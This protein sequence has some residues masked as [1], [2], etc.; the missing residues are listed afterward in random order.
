V[1]CEY[2]RSLTSEVDPSAQEED[3]SE[4][5]ASSSKDADITARLSTEAVDPPHTVSTR[6]RFEGIVVQ[7]RNSGVRIVALRNG[8]FG[9]LWGD[10]Y[11]ATTSLE[12]SAIETVQLGARV[13]VE[14]I[15]IVGTCYTG[16]HS[17]TLQL[18]EVV[19]ANWE[20]TKQRYAIGQAIS[21]SIVWQGTGG[22]VVAL[23]DG[24]SGWLPDRGV[25]RSL[26]M[27]T[28]CEPLVTGQ[29]VDL[30]VTGYT[31]EYRRLLLKRKSNPDKPMS[32][33][34][35]STLFEIG[36][37]IEGVI[38]GRGTSGSVVWISDGLSGWL[39]DTELSWSRNDRTLSNS[40]VIG[41][42]VRLKYIGYDSKHHKFLLS[43]RQVQ[44]HPLDYA[45]ESVFLGN[46]YRGIVSNVLNYGVFVCLPVGFDGLI[47][48][49]H[50]PEG[51]S[52][53]K[54]DKLDVRISSIDKER[55]RVALS[56]I[57]KELAV[58]GELEAHGSVLLGDNAVRS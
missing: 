7:V 44:G 15:R 36:A 49:S 58:L 40:L 26:A 27:R 30:E 13:N 38:A 25:S 51:V 2:E 41:Q 21:G 31:D 14:V 3:E 54:G 22:S 9:A 19:D 56:L 24:A 5:V 34:A 35:Q 39:P 16:P 29:H 12:L 46:A 33:L 37:L 50:L 45:D 10:R 52:P 1:A 17:I 47:H 28:L 6:Q 48:R 18:S 53:L 57:S 8:L 23:S 4:L 55:R 42:P 20:A 32:D 11:Q 43:L